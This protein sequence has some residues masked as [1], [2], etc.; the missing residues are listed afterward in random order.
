M[1]FFLAA[2]G[3]NALGTCVDEPTTLEENE[4]VDPIFTGPN[5]ANEI[6]PFSTGDWIAQGFHS[7]ACLNKSCTPV[8]GVTCKPKKGQN[9]F[10]CDFNGV[11]KLNKINGKS[12]T[13]GKGVNTVLNAGFTAAFIRTL[14]NVVRTAKTKDGIPAYLEQFV[15]AKGL[16][17]TNKTLTKDYGFLPTASCGV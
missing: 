14:F 2:I 3:V 5:A 15:G 1:S 11:L 16:F 9:T 7:A 12:P 8:K 10:G 13:T 4:G 6:I 17:C